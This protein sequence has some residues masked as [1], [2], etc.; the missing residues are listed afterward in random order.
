MSPSPNA[1]VEEILDIT[2][3]L[4]AEHDISGVTVDMIAAKAGVSKATIY[5]RWESRSALI[6]DAMTRLRR[7]TVDPDT[8]SLRE[9]LAILL[10]E[11]VAFLNRPDAGRVFASFLNAAVREPDLAALQQ[12]ISTD[13]R[14]AYQRALKRAI[15]R[16]ELRP[17]RDL[18]FLID[19]LIAPFLYQGIVEHARARPQDIQRVIDMVLSALGR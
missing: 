15:K 17:T 14:S 11:L 13:A 4:I 1:T 6:V 5:R 3:H 12:E 9:D 2:F 10:K 16:G 18:R 19:V 7:P 8:G